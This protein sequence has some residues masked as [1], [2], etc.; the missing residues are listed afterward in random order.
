M[1]A[2]R[3]ILLAL[4]T[5]PLLPTVNGQVNAQTWRRTLFLERSRR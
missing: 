2:T 1:Q 5:I 4:M 3:L